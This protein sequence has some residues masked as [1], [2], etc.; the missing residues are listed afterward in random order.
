MTISALSFLLSG[1]VAD[2]EPTCKVDPDIFCEPFQQIST[3]L[4]SED[5]ERLLAAT[6]R[7]I[8]GM[9]RGFGTAIRNSFGLWHD[10]DLTRF[11]KSNG[12][13]DP[14][15]MSGP[16]ITGLIGYLEGR[17]VVMT[18]EIEKIPPPPPPPPEPSS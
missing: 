12:V 14:D 10:N 11:F 15:S 9:H 1:C 5:K 16:F 13:D 3:E 4:S 6:P 2:S 8:I 7:D 18:E 17:E